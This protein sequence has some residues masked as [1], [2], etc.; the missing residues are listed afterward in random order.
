MMFPV[1]SLAAIGASL[2]GVVSAG[3]TYPPG[4]PSLGATYDS[5]GENIRFRVASAR[6]QNVQLDL[7]DTPFGADEKMVVALQKEPTTGT[8][9]TVVAVADLK[10]QGI[11]GT[12]Y[13]G[14]RAWGPNWPF[15]PAW[16]NG[17]QTGFTCNDVDADGNR[18]NPNK[19]LLDPY[20]VEISHD[21]RNLQNGDGSVFASGP[22]NRLRD[23]GRFAPK[24]IVLLPD[25]T[26][27]GSRPIRPLREEIIYEVHLR[28]LTMRDSTI[29][30]AERGTY[31]GAARKA[32]YLQQLG[33]TAVEFLPVHEFDNDRNDVDPGSKS[34][35]YWGYATLG[36]FAPDRRYARD[37]SPGGPTREF[38]AMV[39]AFHDRGLK[40]YLDVVYNHTGEGGLYSGDP[41][42]VNLLSWRGLDNP[43]YYELTQD[44]RFF[45]DNTGVDGNFNCANGTVRD[46]ITDSLRYWSQVMGVDGFRFDLAPVLGNTLDHQR[47]GG[48]GFIFDKMPD[49]N[50]LNRAVRELPVRPAGGG[51]GVDLIAEPWNARGDGGQQQGNFPSGWAEW[52]DRFRDTF[53]KSQNKLG[54]D[55]VTPGD[56]ATRFAGSRDLYQDDGRK[57]WHSINS[58][59]EHD[60][61]SLR[62]LY[63]YNIDGRRAWDRNGD[64]SLQRQA[65]RNGFALPLLSVG[66]PM[67]TG[68]DEM[69][70]TVG[71]ND[72]PYDIDDTPNYLDWSNTATY[73]NYYDFA[74]RILAFRRAH[75]AL[76]PSEYFDGNDHNG[77]G[78]KDIT[79]YRDDALEPDNAYWAAKDRHFL[80]FRIDGTECGDPAASIYV[81]YN[82]WREPIPISLPTPL[83]GHSWYRASDT[84]AWME[85]QG[86][87]Q[88]AGQEDRLDSRSYQMDRRSVLLLIER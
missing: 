43:T 12:V 13:Y 22:A 48:Q 56:L 20:A 60:G 40:V 44:N 35:D 28:G 84:A 36:Y 58:L 72:N 86:N 11:T 79:W 16:T 70:R 42:T 55:D 5:T 50:P 63:A 66:V 57:P 75:P 69:Y 10:A 65:A 27:V 17:A 47:S 41:A 26:D 15:D 21:P 71:G 32:D 8:W 49:A 3:V 2:S 52:N 81:G 53:R 85:N 77:N 59:V 68:G 74:R 34:N 19:L 51:G 14:Y 25:G 78:L 61:P 54:F 6:A 45:Y 87:A 30:E 37:K 7:Y 76:R 67:F 46:L 62:D 33:V 18:F 23:S 1:L 80:A 31:A 73:K 88:D 9:S 38:K 39:K 82:G 4:T 64:A 29:P 83:T 24:A